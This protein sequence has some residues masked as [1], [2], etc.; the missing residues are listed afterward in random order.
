MQ[1]F[2]LFPRSFSAICQFH[3]SQTALKFYILLHD[4]ILCTYAFC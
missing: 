2:C 3:I 4:H 1:R